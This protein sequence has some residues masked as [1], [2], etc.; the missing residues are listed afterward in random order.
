MLC[1]VIYNIRIQFYI[2]IYDNAE[3]YAFDGLVFFCENRRPGIVVVNLESLLESIRC[4]QSVTEC[5]QQHAI[6]LALTGL[7]RL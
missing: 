3:F 7:P 1:T 5:H 6:P 2:F 4:N